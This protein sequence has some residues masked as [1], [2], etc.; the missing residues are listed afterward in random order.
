MGRVLYVIREDR[1]WSAELLARLAARAHAQRKTRSAVLASLVRA[2]VDEVTEE[3]EPARL[4]ASTQAPALTRATAF[5]SL[6]AI[7]Q[8]K[9]VAL[10]LGLSYRTVQ[11]KLTSGTM[12]PPPLFSRDGSY[13]RPYRFDRDVIGRYRNGTLPRSSSRHRGARR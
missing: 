12:W 5:D 8:P 13:A 7:L 4:R 2:Y 1:H 6:P 3:V 11:A 9:E 10:W